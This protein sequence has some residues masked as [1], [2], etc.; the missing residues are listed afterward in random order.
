MKR[1]SMSVLILTLTLLLLLAGCQGQDASSN[2]PKEIV[3]RVMEATVIEVA[4]QEQLLVEP[5]EGSP[6]L[7]SADRIV[8]HTHNALVLDAA[9]EETAIEEYEVG[10]L[11]HITYDG[12]IAESYPAQIWAEKVQV[13]E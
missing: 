8:A 5:V 9:G 7:G 4:G 11:V 13:V 2:E 3:G 10:S 6:E 12:D 1:T